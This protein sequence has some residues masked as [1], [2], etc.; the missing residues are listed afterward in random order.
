MTECNGECVDLMSDE[1]NC[2][3]CGNQCPHDSH[4]INGAC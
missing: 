2:G 4:C 1:E 3:A